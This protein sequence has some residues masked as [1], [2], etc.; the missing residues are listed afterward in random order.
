MTVNHDKY[1]KL[2]QAKDKIARLRQR[3][4]EQL[5]NRLI[6]GKAALRL[7]AEHQNEQTIANMHRF[8]HSIKGTRRSFGFEKL[9]DAILAVASRLDTGA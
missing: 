3:F 1:A 5:P 2:A 9:S 8:F 4:I 6:E 7:L